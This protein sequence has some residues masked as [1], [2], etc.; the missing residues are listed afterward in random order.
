MMLRCLSKFDIKSEE[1]DEDRLDD[2]T[3]NL[4]ERT[5]VDEAREARLS[6]SMLEGISEGED[7]ENLDEVEAIDTDQEA[8][9]ESEDDSALHPLPEIVIGSPSQVRPQRG[10]K[11]RRG[12]GLYEYTR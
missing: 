6:E 9:E 3:L 7:S 2:L 4:G 5:E 12:E 11:R 1:A 10:R 8:A